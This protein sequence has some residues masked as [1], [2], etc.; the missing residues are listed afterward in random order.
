V[1]RQLEYRL[2]GAVTARLWQWR[3]VAPQRSGSRV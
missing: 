1:A 2:P 3:E